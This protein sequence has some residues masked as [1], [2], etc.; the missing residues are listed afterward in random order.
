MRFMRIAILMLLLPAAL[1]AAPFYAEAS[2]GVR[3]DTT[4][5]SP[6]VYSLKAG[7]GGLS[8]G[9]QHQWESSYDASL[10]Y[11]LAAGKTI[12]NLFLFHTDYVPDEGGWSDLAYVFSQRFRWGFFSLGYGIGVQS[13]VSYSEYGSPP[14]WSLY[15]LLS[16]DAS[17][18]FRHFAVTG[19]FTLCHPDEREW[20]PVPAAGIRAEVRIDW[21][22]GIFVDAYARAAEM[23][24]DPVIMIDT[25]SIRAGYVYRGIL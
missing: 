25:L 15:F 7:Y 20:R 6:F 8:I 3:Y 17:L 4:S 22:H 5:Y 13:G 19:Y 16:L 18:V 1:A 23:L 11:D 9:F 21:H 24:I 2:A 14:M 12:H 10:S